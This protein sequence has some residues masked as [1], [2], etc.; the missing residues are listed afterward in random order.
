MSNINDGIKFENNQA[1]YTSFKNE[2]RQGLKL[3]DVKK[4]FKSC[5]LDP[6]TNTET[7]DILNCFA[8]MRKSKR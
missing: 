1:N 8:V 6:E 3:V 2:W 7:D 4:F 5:P